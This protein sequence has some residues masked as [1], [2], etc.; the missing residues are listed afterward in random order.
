MFVRQ[1]C[2]QVGVAMDGIDPHDV[3]GLIYIMAIDNNYTIM[4]VSQI[5]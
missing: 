5:K 3:K 2:V 1:V 4:K